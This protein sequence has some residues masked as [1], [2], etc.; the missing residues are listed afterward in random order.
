MVWR[1]IGYWKL[2]KVPDGNQ[3]QHKKPFPALNPVKLWPLILFVFDLVRI[4][5]Q[6]LQYNRDLSLYI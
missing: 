2:H 5:Q 4:W 1:Q 3:G 6:W